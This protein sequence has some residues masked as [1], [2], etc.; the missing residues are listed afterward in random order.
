M[1]LLGFAQKI[2]GTQ[3]ERE[4]K[5]IYPIVTKIAEFEPALQKLSDS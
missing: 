2:F 4:L 1:A 5:S 3:N